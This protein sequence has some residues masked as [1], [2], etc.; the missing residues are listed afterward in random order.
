MPVSCAHEFPTHGRPDQVLRM[1]G[2]TAPEPPD[3]AHF[4][5]MQDN[6]R[7]SLNTEDDCLSRERQKNAPMLAVV[8][9]CAPFFLSLV[10][11]AR[12]PLAAHSWCHSTVH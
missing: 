3:T 11:V 9:A 4:G 5:A 8:R 10:I 6:G 7:L 1:V 12:M 2:D